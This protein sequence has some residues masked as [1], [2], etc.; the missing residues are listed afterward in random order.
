MAGGAGKGKVEKI[1]PT[2]STVAAVFS[3]AAE[4]F[5]PGWDRKAGYEQ[6]MVR[7]AKRQRMGIKMTPKG[8]GT[9]MK[10]KR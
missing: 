10:P 7:T 8:P 3:T 6:A 5:T 4:Q 9:L 2:T 1:T